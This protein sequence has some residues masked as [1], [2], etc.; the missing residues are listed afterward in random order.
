MVG[1][2]QKIGGFEVG[3]DWDAQ[4]IKLDEVDE[5]SEGAGGHEGPVDIFGWESW[6]N[7]VFKWVYNGNASNTLAV[8]VK[9]RL[10]HS[11]SAYRP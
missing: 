3:M 1:L 9:G 4:M 2:E 7:K 5:F 6:E 10:V 8:W 11:T